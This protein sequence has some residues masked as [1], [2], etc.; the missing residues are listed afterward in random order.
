MTNRACQP[1]HGDSMLFQ[2]YHIV[3]FSDNKGS[4]RKLRLR[5]G[6][7]V[8]LFL[9]FGALTAGNV[10]LW[11][12]ASSRPDLTGRLELAERT[13]SDQQAQLLDLGG[14]LRALERDL[15]RMRDFDGKLRLMVN[16]D[17]EPAARRRDRRGAETGALGGAD[18]SDFSGDFLPLHRQDLLARKMRSFLDQLAADA[19]QEEVRQQEILEAIR[20]RHDLLAAMPSIWPA[21]GFV[22]SEF[23][24][25]TSPFTGQKEFHKGLD[26]TAPT[27]TPVLAPARGVVSFVGVD[28]A[29]GLS[30]TINH[31]QGLVTH[32]AHL[33]KA[34]V[35]EGQ[36]VER[37]QPVACVGVSGRTTGPHLHYEVRLAGAPLDPMRYIL[38]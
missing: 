5:G 27:G 19:R 23:G 29:Y 28:G 10:W 36:S 16:L 6:I 7:L 35:K 37:G 26:I 31:G 1:P 34:D 9:L 24:Y 3:I 11:R 18:A 20:S 15:V 2:K 17:P 14:K 22:S 13:T 33:Q 30:L 25:R 38:N 8:G 32:Y 4:C 21:D 12:Q